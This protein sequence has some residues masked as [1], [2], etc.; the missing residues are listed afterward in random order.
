[1][2]KSIILGATALVA[3]IAAAPAY[4]GG[5]N[6][7]LPVIG[8]PSY[9]ASTVTGAGAL[10]GATGQGQATTGSICAQTIP[11][12]PAGF[13]GTENA[14][15]DLFAPGTSNGSPVQTALV[16]IQQLWQGALIDVT[17]VATTQTIPAG[18]TFYALDGAQASALTV[19]MP[20]VAI[21][22]QIQK[23]ICEAATVGALTVAANTSIVTQ[24]V[25]NSPGVACVAGVSYTYRYK[26]SNLTWY[27]V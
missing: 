13:S 16:N 25:K 21:D 22:G 20:A 8:G 10:S 19:T 15:V 24:V 2:L 6:Q 5:I 11:A 9:C 12:G 23:I 4:A 18:A 1:M 7:T 3:V 14:R 17:T 27:L 26:L